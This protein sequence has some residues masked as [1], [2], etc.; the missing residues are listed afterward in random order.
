MPNPNLQLPPDEFHVYHISEVY[1]GPNSGVRLVKIGDFVIDPNNGLY[2]VVN[3]GSN[4][5]PTLQ[6]W[7]P[8]RRI[9]DTVE[10]TF[11]D[12]ISSYQPTLLSEATYDKGS[13][14]YLIN[15]DFR[16][17]IAHTAADYVKLFLGM[18]VSD[19]GLVISRNFNGSSEN[20]Q[21]VQIPGSQ[22]KRPE[23][24]YTHAN[25]NAGDVV[26][27]GVYSNTLGYLGK[28]QFIIIESGSVR[29]LGASTTFLS[30]ISLVSDFI[31]PI[32]PLVLNMPSDVPFV[33]TNFS[34]RLHYSDGTHADVG[35]DGIKGKLLGVD[36]FNVNWPAPDT[37]ILLVYKTDVNEPTNA[38]NSDGTGMLHKRYTVRMFDP[39]PDYSFRIYIIPEWDAALGKYKMNYWLVN[40]SHE[41]VHDITNE[42]INVTLMDNTAP[43]MNPNGVWQH[44]QLKFDI[45]NIIPQLGTYMFVQSTKMK[46]T[47]PNQSLIT[48]T[49]WQL[50]YSAL[51]DVIYGS[52]N[53]VCGHLDN[54]ATRDINVASDWQ[55]A[56]DWI[57]DIYESLVPTYMPAVAGGAMPIPT[58]FRVWYRHMTTN[59]WTRN[60]DVID[61][62]D[63]KDWIPTDANGT[64]PLWADFKTVVIEWLYKMPGD[65]AWR[66]AAFSPMITYVYQGPP[67]P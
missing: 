64:Q 27:A 31:D 44:L 24:I 17:Q 53:L 46:L 39:D 6:L 10:N 1:M 30:D 21:L 55:T 35:I 56:S 2:E 63:F 62:V 43:N 40:A 7:N 32:E 26:T 59:Q 61:V 14:P 8:I 45:S 50:D 37:D 66:V 51:G 3:V 16:F 58:H 65:A 5:V 13:Y 25:L 15:L 41:M 19:A 38:I 20:I 9:Y 67:H 22:L 47:T 48:N 29:P 49:P 52:N 4:N 11:E 34:M 36:N 12:A 23:V 18:D 54:N 28:V 60:L 42:P 57:H 33:S